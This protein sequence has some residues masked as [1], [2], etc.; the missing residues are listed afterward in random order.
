MLKHG[1][2]TFLALL[3]TSFSATAM[4]AE[5]TPH[6]VREALRLWKIERD[7][8]GALKAFNDAVSADPDHTDARL[9]RAL[10]LWD[11]ASAISDEKEAKRLKAAALADLRH[12]ASLDPDSTVAAVARDAMAE[13]EGRNLFPAAR[14]DCPDEASDAYGQAEARYHAQDLDKAIPLYE[15]ARKLCP[16]HAPTVLGLADVYYL[17][18]DYGKARELFRA[19][20]EIEPWYR[21]AHRFL[22]DTEAQR[23][24]LAAARREAALA[25]ISDPTYEAG[26]STF[27]GLTEALGGEYLRVYGEKTRVTGDPGG[28]VKIA[29]PA[30]SGK[31]DGGAPDPDSTAWLTYGISRAGALTEEAVAVKGVATPSATATPLERERYAVVAT[32]DALA[33]LDAPDRPG[34][35]S[36]WPMMARAHEAGYLD[37]AIFLHLLDEA[38]VPELVKARDAKRERLLAYL[39]TVVTRMPKA[40]P[41]R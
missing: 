5:S 15:K 7:V 2:A 12:V 28:D 14:A 41:S 4:A 17:K 26:W 6:K 36:F 39:E 38:L 32:L 35:G 34:P 10:F 20:I 19:A 13:L 29:L 37:E 31:G 22:A 21:D 24:E 3:V 9:Q 18:G 23:G 30:G 25:V 1:G 33:E 11:V 8:Q 16:A 27:R 40:P